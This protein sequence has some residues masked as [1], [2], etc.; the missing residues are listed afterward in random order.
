MIQTIESSNCG[1][2][3]WSLKKVWDKD[4]PVIVFV[5]LNPPSANPIKD[6]PTTRRCISFAKKW[7]FGTLIMMNLYALCTPNQT[8]L[9]EHCNDGLPQND[10]ELSALFGEKVVL[11]WGHQPKAIERADYVVKELLRNCQLYHLGL[12][13]H[14]FP[15]HPLFLPGDTELIQYQEII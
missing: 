2:Y 10:E 6:N 14:G 7:G 4:K 15:R 9:Y 13:K 11:A 1:N 8:M 3:R 5:C 12:T